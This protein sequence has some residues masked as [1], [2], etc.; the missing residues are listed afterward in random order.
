MQSYGQATT[1]LAAEQI[2]NTQ[3]IHNISYPAAHDD[4]PLKLLRDLQVPTAAFDSAGRCAEL[5]CHKETRK[6]IKKDLTSWVDSA[7]VT[8]PN[9]KWVNGSVGVG[10]SAVAKWMAEYYKERLQ[11]AASFFFFR[12]GANHIGNFIP[13]I[14]Y[15]IAVSRA[16]PIARLRIIEHIKNDPDIL[17]K[18]FD[19]QWKQLIIE[20]LASIQRPVLIVIDGI[21]EIT[22]PDEQMT[23][24]R[25]I[26]H[27]SLPNPFIKILLVSRPEPQIHQE[28]NA[29]GL[30][31]SSRIS[32]GASKEDEADLRTFLG[33]SLAQVHRLRQ[34][35]GTM[36]QVPSPWP[37]PDILDKLV[38]MA[39]CQFIYATTL[40]SFIDDKNRNPIAALELILQRS[41]PAFSSLDR[42]YLTVM[43]GVRDET[44]KQDRQLLQNLLTHATLS[45]AFD[46]H[47]L[48]SMASFWSTD[49]SLIQIVLERL[50][51]VLI[52]D[53]AFQNSPQPTNHIETGN[54]ITI[55]ANRSSMN[56]ININADTVLTINAESSS[57]NRINCGY[58]PSNQ[59]RITP[60]EEIAF[61]HRSFIDFMFN[62]SFPHPFVI[63]RASFS[64]V[65]QRTLDILGDPSSDL[66]DWAYDHWIGYCTFSLPTPRLLLQVASLGFMPWL[67]SEIY[68]VPVWVDDRH[69]L[70]PLRSM[71]TLHNYMELHAWMRSGV[72]L[73]SYDNEITGR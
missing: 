6:V 25:C 71:Q 63:N 34:Q 22:S 50:E 16:D 36:T 55:N 54:Q 64:V 48:P 46:S 9:L 14:A 17:T 26:L 72:G 43:E 5:Q 8:E 24:L 51:S 73:N 20:P 60:G 21:D 11:L 66:F 68:G 65:A 61:R 37:P 49:S 70:T 13:T 28:F 67:R 40:V 41:S 3:N 57:F 58:Y 45:Q 56:D 4:D 69:N 2:Y 52:N 1:N 53:R 35:N 31:W 42:L 47:C 15:Q 12:Q 29:F 59:C 33:L 27:T 10:K 7:A 23:L 39:D 30:S 62:P 44:P 19:V 18:S 32:L 38:R